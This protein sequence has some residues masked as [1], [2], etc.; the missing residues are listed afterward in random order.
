MTPTYKWVPHFAFPFYH[1][2]QSARC[3]TDFF[4]TRHDIISITLS[5]NFGFALVYSIYFILIWSTLHV[6]CLNPSIRLNMKNL[7]LL[8]VHFAIHIS[9]TLTRVYYISVPV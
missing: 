1:V 3:L 9:L 8:S 2:R 5:G 4:Q 7:V 6:D